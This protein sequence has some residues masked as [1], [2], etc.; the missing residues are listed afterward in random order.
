[1]LLTAGGYAINSP[2][3]RSV[4]V[5]TNGNVKVYWEKPAD[6]FSE[7]KSYEVFYASALAGP[8][9]NMASISSYSV[10]NATCFTSNANNQSYYFYV[11]VKTQLNVTVPAIDTVKSIFLILNSAPFAQ[12][13]DLQWNDFSFPLPSGEAPVYKI[14]REYPLLTW[15]QIATKPVN[16]SGLEAYYYFTDTISVC[17]D[18]INY[19]IELFDPVLG[20]S[21][22]SNVK[23]TQFMD[24]NAPQPPVLDSV[25][26]NANCQAVLGISPSYSGDVKCFV[27]YKW[28]GT[29]VA[30]DTVCTNNTPTVYTYTASTAGS[31]TEEFSIAALDSCGNISQIVSQ[32]QHTIFLQVLYDICGKTANL[33]WNKYDFM[34]GGV[35]HYE[36]LYSVNSGPWIH[37]GDTTTLSYKHKGLSSGNTYCYIIRAHNV[38]NTVT[39]TSCKFCIIPSSAN[40]PAFAYLKNITVINPAEVIKVEWH[41]DNSV[42]LG[43]FQIFR[44]GT[45]SGPYSSVGFVTATGVSTYSFTDYNVDASARQYHYKVQ[46][47]DTCLSPV[48][49]TDSANSMHLTVVPG[50]NL[51]AV[52]NWLPYTKWLGGVQNYNIYRSLDGVY[53]SSPVAT[54]PAGTTSYVD[55]VTAFADY[56]GRITYYVEAE[57]GPGNIYGFTEKSE[58]NYAD[59]YIDASI[60]VPNAFVPKGYNKVFIPVANYIEKT[61]YRFMIFD[62]W[63]EKIFDTGDPT[64]GWDGGFYSQGLYAWVI[65]YKTSIGEHR[66]VKGTVMLVR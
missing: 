36:I 39:S 60:Y 46:L 6:P 50:S 37:L 59:V 15:T 63:G 31:G 7:F 33:S 58:S 65:Q 44:S 45:Y 17:S 8:Y 57:E 13:A 24:K 4:E 62:R 14:Y 56:S 3:I 28:Q 10:D 1:M 34:Q 16:T 41:V 19:R 12:Y 20:Y 48:K 35:D 22:V 64:Q 47:L 25:S 66:E 55:D 43:G 5:L 38:G 21:S 11:Q 52:L 53:G 42:P 30:I 32:R 9:T 27:I 2:Q 18:S 54:V 40:T 49:Y 26:V 51:T 23:G 61:D 29:Y